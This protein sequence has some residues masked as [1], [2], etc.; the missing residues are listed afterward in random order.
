M[1]GYNDPATQLGGSGFGPYSGMYDDAMFGESARQSSD[2]LSVRV[3]IRVPTQTLQVNASYAGVEDIPQFND[4]IVP[5]DIFIITPKDRYESGGF[6]VEGDVIMGFEQHAA[7]L[8]GGTLFGSE[9]E[10]NLEGMRVVYPVYT[11]DPV[12]KQYVGGLEY[13]IMGKVQFEPIGE[14]R[15]IAK[16]HLRKTGLA[17]V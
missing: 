9:A 5:A 7:N 1:R 15:I 4:F 14:T 6:Y 11:K 3:L 10:R 12:T 17:S 16:F 13:R 8:V 2:A